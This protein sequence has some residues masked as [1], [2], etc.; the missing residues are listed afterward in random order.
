[1]DTI[2][3][4][5]QTPLFIFHIQHFHCSLL[6]PFLCAHSCFIFWDLLHLYIVEPCIFVWQ[7]HLFST[8]KETLV[9]SSVIFS[10]WSIV[11]S[12]TCALVK[13]SFSSSI[14]FLV[15]LFLW[16]LFKIDS[17]C[18]SVYYSALNVDILQISYRWQAGICRDS[19]L[20]S[21]VCEFLL[22]FVANFSPAIRQALQGLP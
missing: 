9:I 1:M 21:E 4:Y 2:H 7:K 3:A 5:A 15:Y 8:P 22:P 19:H 12:G 13:V 20:A 16:S 10:S 14:S 17:L 18:F 6:I 11:T